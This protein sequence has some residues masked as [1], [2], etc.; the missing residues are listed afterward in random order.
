MKAMVLRR[1]C[2]ALV[3]EERRGARARAG[4]GA[5]AGRAPARCAAPTCTWWTAN[6]PTSGRRS[7]PGHEIIG[8]VAALGA[9]VD[10]FR[11]GER[12]GVP[13]LGWTC[14]VCAY[15]RGGRENLCPHARFTGYQIDGGFADYTVAD[16]RFCFAI[17]DR[18]RRRGGGAA[19][20]RGAD[21]LP[22]AA[23]G[24]RRA[25]DRLLRLRR[26]GAYRH[27]GGALGRAGRCSPSPGPG[28]AA[29]QD[30]ARRLGAVW[31][32]GS[33][34]A[35]PE[36]LDAALIFAPVGA[37][38]PAALRAVAPGGRGGVR[39]HPHERHSVVSLFP[40]VDGA[41]GAVGG[42]PDA[43]RRRGVPGHRGEGAGRDGD[44]AVSARG[45]ERRR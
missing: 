40:A 26:G 16:A 38:V 4:P 7:C 23:H 25:A 36:P 20:V 11:A 29:A 22:H 45:G 37:L 31:A 21:R 27:P 5:G 9:G 12:V 28:D 8:R 14:G 41:D 1:V 15:C 42:E 33:D 39:R 19:D 34:E 18:L 32:G 13:W 44:D 35:P 43:A 10:R 3:P 30:F 17:P 6:C 2:E 24:R